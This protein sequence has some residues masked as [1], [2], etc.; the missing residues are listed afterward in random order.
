MTTYADPRI[1]VCVLGKELDALVAAAEEFRAATR[2]AVDNKYSS[3]DSDQRMNMSFRV[4]WDTVH[5]DAFGDGDTIAVYEHD[6]VLYALS[7]RLPQANTMQGAI[8]A[9]GFI[10][11]V[12]DNGG[13]AAKIENAGI[14]HG[15]DRWREL[16]RD[17]RKA[18]KAAD[19]VVL[20]RATRLAVTKRPLTSNGFYE[21]L[22]N[23]LVGLPE[24]F[25][26]ISAVKRDRDAV[27]VMDRVADELAADGVDTVVARLGAKLDR[28][29]GYG[30]DFEFKINPWGAV[31]LPTTAIAPDLRPSRPG[32]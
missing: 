5:P 18:Q 1:L 12:L 27:V 15:A 8:D 2:F 14:A 7:P 25:V 11:H 13:T 23:H 9:V 28:K 30:G 20:S 31:K 16:L 4:C 21:S 32:V 26:P 3:D 19:R 6:A 24:V 29:S 10:V 22:G 17:I